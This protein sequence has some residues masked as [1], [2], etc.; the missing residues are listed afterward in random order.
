[1]KCVRSFLSVNICISVL[2]IAYTNE[3]KVDNHCD[4]ES[5]ANRKINNQTMKCANNDRTRFQHCRVIYQRQG[6]RVCVC[7]G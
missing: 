7:I 2:E 6:S 1:M 4:Y 3:R 5:H